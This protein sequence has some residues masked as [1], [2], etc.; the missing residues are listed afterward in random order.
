MS[1][2]KV[3]MK[4][5]LNVL[6]FLSVLLGFVNASAMELIQE[7]SISIQIVSE[8][9][10]PYL[11]RAYRSADECNLW[12]W[13]PPYLKADENYLSTHSIA[14]LSN[15]EIHNR[16]FA[17]ASIY[18]SV[19]FPALISELKMSEL[20]ERAAHVVR[21]L[22]EAGH[23]GFSQC[24]D[25]TISSDIRLVPLLFQGDFGVVTDRS[26]ISGPTLSSIEDVSTGDF[27]YHDLS[28]GLSASFRVDATDPEMEPRVFETLKEGA[29]IFN[30]GSIAGSAVNAR[31]PMGA[32]L[33]VD[34]TMSANFISELIKKK[35][36]CSRRSG[37]LL[38]FAVGLLGFSRSSC[39]VESRISTVFQGC[40]LSLGS[41]DSTVTHEVEFQYNIDNVI[42]SN[43]QG[44]DQITLP[45]CIQ[46]NCE[47]IERLTL[48]Q[49]MQS[50]LLEMWLMS[51]FQKTQDG[52]IKPFMEPR[53]GT[54][55]RV[56][57]DFSGYFSL[58]ERI[59]R[60]E[61]LE[62]IP[63][64]VSKLNLF[65]RGPQARIERSTRLR[66]ARDQFDPLAESFLGFQLVPDIC[67]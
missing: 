5:R 65:G 42:D 38:G 10:R 7:N 11:L 56:T 41:C 22:K 54:N 23:P 50:V 33:R 52:L 9:S 15:L 55:G 37:G 31:T 19:F 44:I 34:G 66:C 8:S 53:L 2:R 35:E 30:L 16:R 40:D 46:D 4:I 28:N 24:S 59:R 18:R 20:R 27:V 29:N 60:I 49:Y 14:R 58:R 17:V 12:Y 21:T 51:N 6:I 39:D 25:Q 63:L 1:K 43:S 3:I 26:V 36:N 32:D 67:F 45:V 47:N 57:F 13:L 62:S 61:R 64:I 48:R